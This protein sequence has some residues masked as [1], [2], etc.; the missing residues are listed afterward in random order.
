[1]ATRFGFQAINNNNEVLIDSSAKN[2]FF[3]NKATFSSVT[4]SETLMGGFRKL[5]YTIVSTKTPMPFF[6]IPTGIYVAL[7][8]VTNT[9]GNNWDIELLVSGSTTGTKP[10]VYV[11][12]EN[13]Y[14]LS[15]IGD[16]GMLVY[17]ETSGIT[18]DS[19]LKP[20]LVKSSTTISP[21]ESP[22]TRS[23][24]QMAT[25]SDH[26]YG[27]GY[28]TP[29]DPS[30]NMNTGMI[31]DN[32]YSKTLS[33]T[34]ITKP[35][36]FYSSIAQTQRD[37][38]CKENLS[39]FWCEVDDK[40]FHTG[41]IIGKDIIKYIETKTSGF[42]RSGIN[43]TI[44]GTSIILTAGWIGVGGAGSKPYV[45]EKDKGYW[46][47]FP[48]TSTSGGGNEWPYKNETINNASSNSVIIADGSMYD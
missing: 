15:P 2:L 3:L 17:N 39:Y 19:R 11:F 16:Y 4:A 26:G 42:Y 28:L 5:L 8:R 21:P 12:I 46:G 25:Y 45:Y 30:Y 35:I 14:I 37:Y 38:F 32:V 33:D 7:T 1:M 18:F 10:T 22:F 31:P 40:I 6:T 9:S 44:S 27:R 23:T 34:I 29:D 24:A 43:G 13:D 36:Y 47:Q 20:L 48:E 41:C